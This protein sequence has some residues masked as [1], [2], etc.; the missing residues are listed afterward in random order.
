MIKE[1]TTLQKDQ[2]YE[3]VLFE[4]HNTQ[5]RQIYFYKQLYGNN[6]TISV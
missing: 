1:Y 3:V 6:T 5:L 2:F 4:V